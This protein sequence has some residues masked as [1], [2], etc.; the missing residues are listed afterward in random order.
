LEVA[1][2]RFLRAL[3]LRRQSPALDAIS[4]APILDNIAV[5]KAVSGEDQEARKLLEEALSLDSSGVM[6]NVHAHT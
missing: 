3:E 6:T 5:L 2:R 1:D 4:I